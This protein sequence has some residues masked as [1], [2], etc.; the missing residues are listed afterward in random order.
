[1]SDKP[2]L[3]IKIDNKRDIELVEFTNS[4]TA[5][6]DEYS[7]FIRQN[8]NKNKKPV[9]F[10]LFVKQ[11]KKGSIIIDICEKGP[12]LLP[13]VTPLIIEYS[14]FLTESIKYL[15]GK[16]PDLPKFYNFFKEDF[17]NLKKLF[18]PVANIYGNS[19]G[20]V[21]IN[22]GEV[23]INTVVNST[24]AGAAQNQ[25]D[26]EI[27]RLEKSGKNL[28][29]EKVELDLYQARDSKLSKTLRGNLGIIS[30]ISEAPKPLSFLNERLAYDITKGETN[31]LNYIYSVDVE[32]KLKDGSLFLESDKDIKEYE[33]LALH[34]P[35]KKE[36]L[37]TGDHT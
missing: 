9:E 26:K 18:E 29:R 22:F 16:T 11:I 35:I 6:N 10:S 1:M 28:L 31:P 4:M 36:D 3:Q 23:V 34:G 27:K 24:E 30:D 33:V 15:T 14:C 7:R 25:C 17:I 12:E 5:L 37:F 32:V 21:G 13:A 8:K 19:I 20:F 2:I